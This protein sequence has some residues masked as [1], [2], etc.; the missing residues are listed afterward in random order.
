M[1][2]GESASGAFD[3]V[4]AAVGSTTIMAGYANAG[5][6][7]SDIGGYVLNTPILSATAYFYIRNGNQGNDTVTISLGVNQLFNSST[8]APFSKR[9]GLT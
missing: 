8:G 9:S 7:F 1:N 5:A 3:I 2:A 6:S 4:N